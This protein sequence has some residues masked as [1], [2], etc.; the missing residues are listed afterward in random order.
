[1]WLVRAH[2]RMCMEHTRMCMEHTR[3]CMEH[4]LKRSLCECWIVHCKVAELRRLASDV[5]SDL[6]HLAAVEAHIMELEAKRFHV[7]TH[8]HV[9]RARMCGLGLL[10]Q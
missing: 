4:M 10:A 3:M 8:A 7:G 6:D 1:M 2:T 5:R 9:S